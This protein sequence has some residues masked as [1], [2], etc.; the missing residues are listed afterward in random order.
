[1]T[2]VHLAFVKK[3]YNN[4]ALNARLYTPRRPFQYD[5][6]QSHGFISV[7]SFLLIS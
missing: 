4:A 7:V 6:F 2:D 5:I 1:M 3:A